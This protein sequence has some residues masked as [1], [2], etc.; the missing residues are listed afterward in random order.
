LFL[1]ILS[2]ILNFFF[3]ARDHPLL[4][5]VRPPSVNILSLVRDAAARLP[6]GIGTRADVALLLTDSQFVVSDAEE[7]QRSQA[8]SSAL[9]RLHSE[10]DPCVKYDKEQKLWIYLHRRRKLEDFVD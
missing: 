10:Y 4:T 7:S 1:T 9:D 6:G 3:K 8:V 2:N 5:S